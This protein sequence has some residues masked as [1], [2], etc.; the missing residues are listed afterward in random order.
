MCAEA[1]S[2][3]LQSVEQTGEIIGVLIA[4]G[5]V[6]INHLF[7]TDDSL[8]FCRANDTECA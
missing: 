5:R 3:M 8:L 1:L 2:A 7:F 6:R 4:C